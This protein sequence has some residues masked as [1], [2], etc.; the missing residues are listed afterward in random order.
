MKSAPIIIDPK[1]RQ[2]LET[3]CSRHGMT[4]AEVVGQL[5]DLFLAQ[6]ERGA[7]ARGIPVAGFVRLE[8]LQ[9]A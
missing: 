7:D 4:A 5:V 1:Q 8:A 3:F 9:E 2:R 6:A